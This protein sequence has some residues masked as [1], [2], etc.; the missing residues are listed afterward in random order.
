MGYQMRYAQSRVPGL[1]RAVRLLILINMVLYIVQH[2]APAGYLRVFGLVPAYV[3]GR[4]Y[5]WQLVTYMFLH[6]GLLHIFF[7]M[8]FLWMMG[9]E[10]ERYWGSREFLKYYFVTG[11]G[12]G[13]I[14]VLVQPHS[15]IPIIGASGA[16]FGLIIAFGMAFPDRELLL[17]F[18]IRI[19]AK[20]FAVLI[21]LIEL[22][23]L[24][25]LP[26]A[27]IARFA[28]LGGLVVG[29]LYLKW[30][31]YS[32]P[33]KRY[34]R[35]ARHR[36]EESVQRKHDDRERKTRAEV[37]RLL[38]KIGREGLDSLSSR[39]RDFLNRQSGKGS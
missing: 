36:R 12:A 31:R 19:K 3:L 5:L 33:F 7:N 4:A 39:E 16:V 11:A 26:N 9:S 6:G 35:E 23:S 20:H 27:G 29:Y 32:Y 22:I 1:T 24:L 25:A 14:N 10:L 21:G 8:L 13:V 28:H 2:F 34:Y 37:D 17:Y 15:G 38:D 18:F 30:E